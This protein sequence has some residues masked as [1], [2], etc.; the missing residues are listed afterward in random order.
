MEGVGP[1]NICLAENFFKEN[2]MNDSKM[3]AFCQNKIL[4]CLVNFYNILE[5]FFYYSIHKT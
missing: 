2:F 1:E 3:F 5:F 4:Y